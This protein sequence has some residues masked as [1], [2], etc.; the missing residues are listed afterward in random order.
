MKTPTEKSNDTIQIIV[1]RTCDLFYC[2]NCTQLLPFRSDTT[3]MSPDVFRRALRSLDGWPGVRGM[4]G[5]NPCTHPQFEELCRIMVE[6]VPDQR[7]RGIWTNNFLSHGQVVRDTFYPHGRFNL[8]AHANP[9]IAAEM[10]R[11]TPGKV[12]RTSANR[13][14][15][16]SPVLIGYRDV[17][18]SDED[19]P[20][21]RKE[22]DI[23]RRWSAAIREHDGEPMAYFCEVAAAMDGVTGENHGIPAV[24][25]WW[26]WGI[27]RFDEQ[28]EKCCGKCGIPLR[29]RGHLDVDKTYDFSKTH[30]QI[31]S[32]TIKR[33]P[34]LSAVKHDS[35]PDSTPMA[36]DYQKLWTKT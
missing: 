10:E 25:G 3:H 31:V 20:A 15:W 7:Q 28:V 13:A 30:E 34:H 12:I 17:G 24:P 4:F 16:H 35:P 5:G 21:I 9:D 2:S 22:C 26:R 23:N 33:R 8:N 18:I 14:S 6:E 11:W 32:V 1:T 36:T 19:W 29:G 27:E